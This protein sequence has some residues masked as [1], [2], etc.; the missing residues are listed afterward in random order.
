MLFTIAGIGVAIALL[1]IIGSYLK[2]GGNVDDAAVGAAWLSGALLT[3]LGFTAAIGWKDASRKPRGGRFA[4]ACFAGAL[5][6]HAVGMCLLAVAIELLYWVGGP[7]HGADQ[8]VFWFWLFAGYLAWVGVVAA[9]MKGVTRA[10]FALRICTATS[11]LCV[12]AFGAGWL[13]A[14]LASGQGFMAGLISALAA[15]GAVAI[16]VWTTV[17]WGYTLLML[18][19][20]SHER[21]V[22]AWHCAE[23]DYDLRGSLLAG[24]RACPECGA[25]AARP[26][27]PHCREDVVDDLLAGTAKCGACGEALTDLS[28]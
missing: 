18:D 11:V 21:R 5:P 17:P 10:R 15:A 3:Q 16:L 24:R 25:P 27:C 20:E 13:G 8:A 19:R 6:L 2:G 12:T 28:L 1:A 7:F 26:L 9:W 14:M 4:L 22:S 23:C